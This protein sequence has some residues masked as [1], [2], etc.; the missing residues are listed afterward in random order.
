MISY[1]PIDEPIVRVP[2][3]MMAKPQIKK[4]PTIMDE[5]ECNYIVMFFIVGVILLSIADLIKSGSR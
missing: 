1:A 3:R 5:S 4:H 2:P